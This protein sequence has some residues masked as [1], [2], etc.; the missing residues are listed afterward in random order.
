[1]KRIIQAVRLLFLILLFVLIKRQALLVWLILYAVSLLVPALFGKRV[2]CMA[3][4][5]I[6][7]LMLGAVW[8]KGKL[9]W[10]DRPA[11]R[12]LRSSW[13]TW[14][15]LA[16]TA[17]LFILSRKVLGR[18]LPVMLLWMAL[19]FFLT[20]AFHPDLFHDLI[21]P[22][23]ALQRALSRVSVLSE[24]GRQ[25]ALNYQGFT[26]SVLAAGNKEKAPDSAG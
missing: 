12:W 4:C 9:G 20:L 10:T 3:V 5:P 22:Y 23:G 6:N 1:M 8:L 18:D 2:Y 11:P 24:E 25:K 19:G 21:C 7:T 26:R 14:A 13:L 15:S 16:L 17:G